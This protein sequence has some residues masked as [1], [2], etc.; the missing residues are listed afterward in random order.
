MSLCG[1]FLWPGSFLDLAAAPEVG[2]FITATA[3]TS[4]P[5][6]LQDKTFED[7]QGNQAELS[8]RTL[9]SI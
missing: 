3:M 7:L 6:E 9:P 8:V 4:I 5:N 1:N 2:T